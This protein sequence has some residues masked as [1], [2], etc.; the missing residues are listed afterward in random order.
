M[1]I[2]DVC[3]VVIVV[4][5]YEKS[6]ESVRIGFEEFDY[7]IDDFVVSKFAASLKEFKICDLY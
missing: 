3:I 5:D 6:V 2:V 4:R 1:N 7:L